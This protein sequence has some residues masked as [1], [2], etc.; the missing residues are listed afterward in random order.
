MQDD[1]HRVT[2]AWVPGHEEITEQEVSD[3]QAKAG[4]RRP[5]TLRFSKTL[6]RTKRNLTKRLINK[7]HERH[8]AHPRNNAYS[9]ADRFE[10]SL[11]PTPHLRAYDKKTLAT[12]TQCRSGHAFT[13][14][15]YRSINKPECGLARPCGGASA[16]H[17]KPANIL[18]NAQGTHD[19]VASYM[20]HPP[21]KFL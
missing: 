4:T 2:V 20:I 21:P 12:L 17:C 9:A 14:K 10:P 11:R 6:T 3:E 1:R 5:S 18:S 8:H 15:Y 19:I 13:G 7:W 16:R